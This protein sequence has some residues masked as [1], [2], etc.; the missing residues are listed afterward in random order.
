[1]YQTPILFVIF[2][3]P[4]TT[5]RVFEAIQKIK[6]AKLY[7]AADGPRS[8]KEG[9]A[10]L[11]EETR[12]L[13]ENV[14]WP[15]E[16]Y[17]KYSDNNL[18]CKKGVSGAISW[19]FDNVEEGIILE[20]DCLPNP[21]FFSFCAELLAK[22]RST[23]KV[24]MISG[25][26]FQFGKKYGEASYYFSHFPHIWGWAT[27]RRAWQ[28]YDIEM[29]TYPEFK[30]NNHIAQIFKN[31]KIQ[32]YWLKIFDK[33]YEN[34]IDTWDGQLVYSIYNKRG[35]VILPNVNLISNIGFGEN[36]TH[37]K[38]EDI[39]SEIPTGSIQTIIHPVSI[40]VN[41]GADAN[42]SSLLI[43]TVFMRILRKL[44]S[45]LD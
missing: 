7:I 22:Y 26:N 2:N 32:K 8:S 33:L 41:E 43:K 24:K 29:K 31:K 11:C 34:K 27:W 30:K 39:F 20:D 42:Y 40:M 19:F 21:S 25:D 9:E 23:D 17:R 44:Q 4:D 10:K 28:E 18:G 37:T 35:V 3:R 1:M 36:A 16:V 6:P 15:C 12:R 5:K 14:D 38:T 45:V 13:T